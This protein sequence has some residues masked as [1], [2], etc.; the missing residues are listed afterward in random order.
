MSVSV[1]REGRSLVPLGAKLVP[2]LQCSLPPL[3]SGQCPTPSIDLTVTFVEDDPY[4]GIAGPVNE[5]IY[6]FID[7]DVTA[8][9]SFALKTDAASPST[10]VSYSTIL[11]VFGAGASVPLD[12]K[13]CLLY[14][15]DAADE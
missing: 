2:T 9:T 3:S 1:G 14:T 7:D 13:S 11:R 12:G 15:S 5:P 8:S 6:N 10:D 4:D